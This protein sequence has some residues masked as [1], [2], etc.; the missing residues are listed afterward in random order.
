MSDNEQQLL[1]TASKGGVKAFEELTAP[2]QIIVYNYLLSE[3]GNE[4]IASQLTQDVFV[5][6]FELLNSNAD[7]ENFYTCIYRTA[8]E[9]SQQAARESKMIS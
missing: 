8:R 2:H 6:I 9:V 4:F 1:K 5:R 3:C 7:T